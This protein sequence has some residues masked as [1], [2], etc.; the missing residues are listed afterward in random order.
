LKLLQQKK[1]ANFNR[2]GFSG[3]ERKYAGVPACWCNL[4]TENAIIQHAGMLSA[5]TQSNGLLYKP[6]GKRFRGH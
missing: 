4:K 3:L 1:M 6:A 5:R 2:S